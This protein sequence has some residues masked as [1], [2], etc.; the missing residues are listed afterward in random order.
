LLL[1]RQQNTNNFVNYFIKSLRRYQLKT[2][3]NIFNLKKRNVCN[4]DIFGIS[5]FTDETR[6]SGGTIVVRKPTPISHRHQI[7]P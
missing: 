5:V 6:I 2:K 4:Y 7:Q 1:G 3:A